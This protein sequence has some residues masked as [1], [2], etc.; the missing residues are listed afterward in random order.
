MS[1]VFKKEK[2]LAAARRQREH[3]ERVKNREKMFQDAIFHANLLEDS[4]KLAAGFGDPMAKE[5]IERAPALHPEALAK[6]FQSR[7][8]MHKAARSASRNAK[9]TPRAKAAGGVFL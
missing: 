3:R 7:A 6:F 9:R 8:E 2:R 5:I 1:M 4:I